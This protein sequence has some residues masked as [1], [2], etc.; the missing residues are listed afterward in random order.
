MAK[1][2]DN[3]YNY[4]N[5]AEY[6]ELIN[7]FRVLAY[8]LFRFEG[9]PEG[10]DEEYIRRNLV[11]HGTLAFADDAKYGYICLK[12]TPQD[13]LNIYDKALKYLLTSGSYSKTFLTKEIALLKINQ[14]GLPLFSLL[15]LY[16]RKISD[17]QR[18]IDVHL[19]TLKAPNIIST[20][21]KKTAFS[22]KTAFKKIEE[23]QSLV[24]VDEALDA[25]SINAQI[26]LPSNSFMADKLFSYKVELKNELYT[27]LGIDNNNVNKK[28]RLL[29][30]EV[31][32]NNDLINYNAEN[33][34]SELQKGIDAIN[35]LFG[36][37][38]S[39]HLTA[40]PVKATIEEEETEEE[41]NEDATE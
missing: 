21:D 35:E 22:I 38:V 4:N 1:N 25:K 13:R 8:K 3:I 28:E 40:K 23:N 34:L 27:I 20:A 10:V 16:A 26:L 33:M 6:V 39:V 14:L 24:I 29:V 11:E 18:T 17:V 5:Y 36:L 15:D 7:Q 30:D 37:N 32:A 31:N 12:A 9:L 19:N 2:N 41:D